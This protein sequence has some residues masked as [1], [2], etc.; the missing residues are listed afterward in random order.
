MLT[1]SPNA[2]GNRPD[3]ARGRPGD[4]LRRAIDST[5]GPGEIPMLAAVQTG[6][7]PAS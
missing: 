4:D 1:D 7:K 2:A 3:A 5:R 6:G